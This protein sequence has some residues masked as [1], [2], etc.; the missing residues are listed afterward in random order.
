[1]TPRAFVVPLSTVLAERFD[2]ACLKKPISKPYFP[3]PRPVDGSLFS[4]VRIEFDSEV[5]SAP[6][7]SLSASN[8]PSTTGYKLRAAVLANPLN[9]VATMTQVWWYAIYMHCAPTGSPTASLYIIP[10]EKGTHYPSYISKYG[11]T[12]G[13]LWCAT[14]GPDSVL[15]LERK[16]RDHWPILRSSWTEV[17]LFDVLSGV[18]CGFSD[19]LGD[20]APCMSVSWF[21]GKVHAP[22]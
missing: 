11:L 12:R 18:A 2:P 21:K 6:F 7:P 3:L 14:L 15:F 17:E 19:P 10:P 8:R 9:A 4:G 16:G 13:L 5:E 22:K 1:V 20:Q